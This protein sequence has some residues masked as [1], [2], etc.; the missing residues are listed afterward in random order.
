MR[1]SINY[2]ALSLL[3]VIMVILLTCHWT[4]CV[5]ALTAN[6]DPLNSWAYAKEYCVDWADGATLHDDGTL[7]TNATPPATV[8]SAV[9]CNPGHVCER[10][11]CSDDGTGAIVCS[12]GF[13]C[14]GTFSFYTYALYFAIMTRVHTAL[15]P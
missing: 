5:W 8:L 14:V 2:D 6:M 7:T 13:M 4:A 15:Q 1:L 10:G 3:T 9:E 11:I 12:G